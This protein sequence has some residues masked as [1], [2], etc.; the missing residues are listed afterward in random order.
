M[1]NTLAIEQSQ[2]DEAAA[3]DAA[4]GAAEGAATLLGSCN[5]DARA[6]VFALEGLR[7]ELRATRI[8]L[9]RNGEDLAETV[10]AFIDEV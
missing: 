3:I 2:R 7:Q 6:I 8:A 1:P 10:S 9:T 5:G 4:D